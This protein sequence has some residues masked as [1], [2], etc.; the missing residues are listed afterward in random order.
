VTRRP[1]ALAGRWSY[2][3]VHEG[4]HN[5][6]VA[7]EIELLAA[8]EA[9]F[10]ITGR[11]LTRWPNPHPDRSPL[12]EEYSRLN[13]P[14]KW[15][16][17]GARTDAWL[18]ALVDTGLAAVERDTSIHWRVKPGMVI[19]RTE[20]IVPFAAG[21]LPLVVARSQ[22]GDIDDAGVALGVGDPA[23]WAAW[24]PYCGCDAC[25]SGSQDE[26]DRLDAHVHSIVSGAFRRLSES[27]RD[28]EI[29]VIDEGVWSASGKFGRHE[30][31]AILA[32]PTGWDEVAGRSWLR[33]S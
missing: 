18:V 25:D 28:R 27:A 32:D 7:T 9:A 15:R 3:F 22:F 31:D 6:V 1:V 24:F 13:D 26:L 14:G 8:V 16:I 17:I 33:P 23:I 5:G 10:E 29:T 21:A 20:R 2:Q 12:G 4:E 11:G 30:L 19:S